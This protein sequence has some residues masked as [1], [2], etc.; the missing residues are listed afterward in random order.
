MGDNVAMKRFTTKKTAKISITAVLFVA[1]G[2]LV[3][4]LLWGKLF[5]Y[6]HVNVGFSNHELSNVIIFVQQGAELSNVSGIDSC[7]PAIEE[8]HTLKFREKPR[9]Y[10]FR[11]KDSYL[12]RST[13][14]ARF[15]AYPNGSVVI[16]PWAI[17]EAGDG[18]ISLKTYLIHE[19]SHTLLYQHMGVVAAYTYYPRWLMEGIA[20]Y[21]SK[22]MGT[23]WY[24]SKKETYDYIN[25]GNFIDPNDYATAKE[26]EAVLNVEY[27]IAFIYSEFGCIVDDLIATYGK[28]AF[29][30]YM[31]LQ[32]DDSDCYGVFKEAF[33]IDFKT[34]LREFKK[35]VHE[36]EDT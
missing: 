27:R 36:S 20:M 13:T 31:K 19:L 26:D 6:S 11:D 21:S 25:Q 30:K 33:G 28:E 22:Q 23:S 35:R 18:A 2:L 9:L 1:A 3:Y 10:V 32:L 14:K 4:H 5:A 8:W 29:L 7:L 12:N 24:P 17:E 16:A 34:Y 15:C